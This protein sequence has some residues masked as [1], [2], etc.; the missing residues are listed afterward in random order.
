MKN[1]LLIWLILTCGLA[2][3]QPLSL[4][5]AVKTDL[6]NNI[7]IKQYNEKYEQKKTEDRSSWGNFLFKIS[8]NGS[9]YHMND[10]LDSG[11]SPVRD[12][13]INL[14]VKNMTEFINVS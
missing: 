7:K 11:L 10:P 1:L 8:L 14:Q 13:I 5:N 4:E 6:Q 12:V 9:Y 2:I 3:A